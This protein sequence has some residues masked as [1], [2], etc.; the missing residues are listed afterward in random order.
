MKA[1]AQALRRASS[2]NPAPTCGLR[3]QKLLDRLQDTLP[4]RP[5]AQV[6]SLEHGVY[7]RGGLDR[8]VRAVLVHEDAGG[9]VDVEV[10]DQVLADLAGLNFLF[11][12]GLGPRREVRN[13]LNELMRAPAIPRI[14]NAVIGLDQFKRLTSSHPVRFAACDLGAAHT[15]WTVRHLLGHLVEEERYRHVENLGEL[16]KPACADPIGASLVLLNLLEGDPHGLPK[17]CLAHAQQRAAQ[18]NSAADM[19]INNL[20]PI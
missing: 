20:V 13:E 17:C 19:R 4:D 2:V 11:G 15:R 3:P 14:G 10:G 8:G 6:A 16:K 12:L 7:A 9:A 1:P 5:T 18:T